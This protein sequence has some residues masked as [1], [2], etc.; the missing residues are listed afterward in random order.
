MIEAVLRRS[1]GRLY[2][3]YA[4]V[5]VRR[6]GDVDDDFRTEISFIQDLVI[7]EESIGYEDSYGQLHPIEVRSDCL[8][9]LRQLSKEERKFL[10]HEAVLNAMDYRVVF[11]MRSISGEARLVRQYENQY[12]SPILK[13][14]GRS[15]YQVQLSMLFSPDE[16][17][18]HF[19]IVEPPQSPVY[20]YPEN[21]NVVLRSSEQVRVRVRVQVGGRL[22]LGVRVRGSVSVLQEWNEVADV[23]NGWVLSGVSGYLEKEF[24]YGG[25]ESGV[26][27][28]FFGRVRYFNQDSFET[29]RLVCRRFSA[30]SLSDY[31]TSIEYPTQT[32]FQVTAQRNTGNA[33]NANANQVEFE[34]SIG[35]NVQG[36]VSSVYNNAGQARGIFQILGGLN[37]GNTI[38]VKARSRNSVVIGEWSDEIEIMLTLFRPVPNV[39][40]FTASS[41]RVAL[42]ASPTETVRLSFI[43][44]YEDLFGG[45]C[46]WRIVRA[47]TLVVIGSGVQASPTFSG[48]ADF[49]IG[50]N[51]ASHNPISFRLVIKRPDDVEFDSLVSPI[52]VTFVSRPDVSKARVFFNPNENVFSNDAATTLAVDGNGVA[53]WITSN[54]NS[55]YPPR[56][57]RQPNSGNRPIYRIV[58]AT[59]TL[60]TK[61]Y[62]IDSNGLKRLDGIVNESYLPP[63]NDSKRNKIT[64]MVFG[65]SGG[66]NGELVQAVNGSPFYRLSFAA[67]SGSLWEFTNAN[68]LLRLIITY[69][70]NN[71]FTLFVMTFTRNT[72]N[73]TKLFRGD[74][75]NPTTPVA[76]VDSHASDFANGVSQPHL[77]VVANT[78]SNGVRRVGHIIIFED[79]DISENTA[80]LQRWYNWFKAIYKV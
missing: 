3:G 32:S 23:M 57:L 78:A 8:F 28:E 21:D 44:F 34:W 14:S 59:Q 49:N 36:I 50:N 1:E 13:Q 74:I 43:A 48:S 80:E 2:R 70:A 65:F 79:T 6:H 12:I 56:E 39:L 71:A 38:F 15:Q 72:A 11:Y 16:A 26:L 42:Q 46:S 10:Y 62:Y 41:E 29:T 55:V 33:N 68:D 58:P 64:M 35:V 66:G 61:R 52:T 24:V 53:V 30:P 54:P 27:Y 75:T 5:Y 20:V 25:G 17:N 4:R 31:P 45:K 77:N 9:S 37:S 47:D 51:V 69:N 19:E 76:M 60:P 22:F 40:S 7:T 63:L 18:E 67:G 73:G